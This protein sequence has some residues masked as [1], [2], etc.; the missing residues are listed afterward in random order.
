MVRSFDLLADLADAEFD[1]ESYNGKSLIAT[2]SA[3]DAERAVANTT[4]EGY[5]AWAVASHLAYCK[6]VVAKSLLGKGSEELGAY[7]Y[8]QENGGFGDPPEAS[9]EAWA[10]FIAY[11]RRLHAVA[12]RAIRERGDELFDRELP[13]WKI[14]IGKAAVWLCGHDGYH[15]AQIR[16]M[17]VPGLKRDRVY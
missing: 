13:E 2:L 7:P 4:F 16:S 9:V 5:S 17:G 11:L 3:L 8:T 10:L 1:G 12:M 15:T 6:W 14:P